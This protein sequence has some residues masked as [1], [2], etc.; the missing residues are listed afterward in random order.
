MKIMD[1]I[2]IVENYPTEKNKRPE[3]QPDRKTQDGRP[4]EIHMV[5]LPAQSRSSLN[6]TA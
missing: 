6:Q 2:T 4:S 1:A 5:Q 3:C